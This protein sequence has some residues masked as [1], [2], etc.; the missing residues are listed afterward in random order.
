MI[1]SFTVEDANDDD[2]DVL[3]MMIIS[4]IMMTDNVD[5]KFN[6]DIDD[7]ENSWIIPKSRIL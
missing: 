1:V 4:I 2:Y 7:N 6:N 3:S 5:D